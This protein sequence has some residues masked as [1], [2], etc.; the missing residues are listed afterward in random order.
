MQAFD[1]KIFPFQPKRQPQGL[2]DS[3]PSN[4]GGCDTATGQKPKRPLA[5]LPQPH[6]DNFSENALIGWTQR[7]DSGHA[8]LIKR[9]EKRAL[10]QFAERGI[11]AAST[12]PCRQIL[13][14]AEDRAPKAN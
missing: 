7:N 8:R 3:A 14:R 12:L 10:S 9:A 6:G 5:Q 11:Y 13:K 4:Q 2:S 1:V